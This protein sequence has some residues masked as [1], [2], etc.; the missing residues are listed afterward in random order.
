[1]KHSL[2]EFTIQLK[3][4]L[5]L[6]WLESLSDEERWTV[7][8][9]INHLVWIIYRRSGLVKRGKNGQVVVADDVSKV[10]LDKVFCATTGLVKYIQQYWGDR[11][12]SDRKILINKYKQMLREQ[13]LLQWVERKFSDGKRQP[14]MYVNLKPADLLLVAEMLEKLLLEEAYDRSDIRIKGNLSYLPLHK[15]YALVRI[16][17]AVFKGVIT[18]RRVNPDWAEVLPVFDADES[19]FAEF[20]ARFQ[21]NPVMQT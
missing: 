20:D 9:M 12:C 17:N 15:A 13:G 16:F 8:A 2:V 11:A 21:W 7:Y 10:K 6:S 19:A 18:W 3:R 14:T 1:M 4:T 5:Y